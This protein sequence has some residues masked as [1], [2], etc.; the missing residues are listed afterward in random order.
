[1]QIPQRLAEIQ[2][3]YRSKIPPKKRI[4]IKSSNEAFKV[5]SLIWDKDTVEYQERCYVLYLNKGN[6]ILGYRLL[7]IGGI[8][9][10][11]VDVRSILGVAL[12]CNASSI[13]LCHNHPSGT[14]RPSQT[15]INL[16]KKLVS[17]GKI[18]DVCI[19]DHLILVPGSPDYSF[20]SFADE[21]ML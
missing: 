20:Y 15:D 5:F 12:K 14:H 17:S 13:I 21:G 7:S 9:G 16:T 2:V 6:Y 18:L 10:T 8:S 4:K 11:V 1:M 19:L 3:S